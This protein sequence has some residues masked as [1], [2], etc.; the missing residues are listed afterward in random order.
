MNKLS[1]KPKQVQ[2]LES[3]GRYSRF[4]LQENPFPLSPVNKNSNDKRINGEIYEDA[5]R[6]KEFSQ[7]ENGFLKQPQSNLNRLRLGYICD[8]SYIGRGNGKSAFLVNLTRRINKEFCLDISDEANKCF[9]LYVVPEAGGRT[10]T[11]TSFIEL[12]FVSLVQSGILD[13][14]LAS[15]RLDAA[16][17][18]YPDVDLLC[19]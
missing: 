16:A 3:A 8:T 1:R 13:I 4:S 5:I 6:S 15:L 2:V 12:I 14:C 17:E 9:A 7:V 10:K 11:F 19:K 18:L